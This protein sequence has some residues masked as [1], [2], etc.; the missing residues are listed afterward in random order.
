MCV[1]GVGVV[2]G[3][4]TAWLLTSE[5]HPWGVCICGTKGGIRN[6]SVIYWN[7]NV[8]S[9]RA[10]HQNTTL[11]WYGSPVAFAEECHTCEGSYF[12]AP[13]GGLNATPPVRVYNVSVT[14]VALV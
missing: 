6:K 9:I 1:F 3:C 10:I 12:V 7:S 2:F 11:V 4:D 14:T 13:A 5:S 8:S